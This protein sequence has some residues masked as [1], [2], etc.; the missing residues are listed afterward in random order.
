MCNVS[1]SQHTAST[2]EKL[3]EM[4]LFSN[5]TQTVELSLP[6]LQL[7]NSPAT[8][9]SENR[10]PMLGV[11]DYSNSGSNLVSSG[12]ECVDNSSSAISEISAATAE[13]SA[14]AAASSAV[15]GAIADDIDDDVSWYFDKA[16]ISDIADDIDRH[17]SMVEECAY[18]SQPIVSSNFAK[19]H[20]NDFDL[21]YPLQMF[22]S[23]VQLF[24]RIGGS[25]ENVF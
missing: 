24:N 7:Y 4:S 13:I 17:K 16:T 5:D 10:E 9:K 23:D 20:S 19:N 22:P 11:R 14:T 8:V 21:N 12:L 3:H 2:P 15:T 18:M 25:R 6:K 1:L